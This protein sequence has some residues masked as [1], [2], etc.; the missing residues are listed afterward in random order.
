M[1]LLQGKQFLKF[2]QV[3]SCWAHTHNF[4]TFFIFF[5]LFLFLS[6]FSHSLCHIPSPLPSLL[7][8][9]FF[10]S[11]FL[12][13]PLPFPFPSS[14]SS[15]LR[16]SL[17][18]F[19]PI[20][21]RLTSLEVS[22]P[23]PSSLLSLPILIYL[24]LAFLL[25]FFPRLSSLFISFSFSLTC[26][27]SPSI[28]PFFFFLSHFNSLP[29]HPLRPLLVSPSLTFFFPNYNSLSPSLL[30]LSF[31]STHSSFIPLPIGL[32]E[33]PFAQRRREGV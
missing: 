26:I 12:P 27:F 8:I 29:F 9:H 20:S 10:S 19:P 15:S 24:S 23:H 28:L 11:L 22:S 30:S 6:F 33:G 32:P 2:C 5:C 3:I 14:F 21:F 18:M 17:F 4:V 31:L 25:L 13:H 16:L 7:F 1:T